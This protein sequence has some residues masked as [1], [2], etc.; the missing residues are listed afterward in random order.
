MNASPPSTHPQKVEN[1]HQMDSKT[2]ATT[3]CQ[4]WNETQHSVEVVEKDEEEEEK[5]RK[6]GNA[7]QLHTLSSK[8]R[9]KAQSGEKKKTTKGCSF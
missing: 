8:T 7:V 3:K 1:T 2:K 4:T 9:D 5:I 6:K